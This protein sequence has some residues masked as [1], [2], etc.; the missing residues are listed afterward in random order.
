LV[1]KKKWCYSSYVA[2]TPA[3]GTVPVRICAVT[4]TTKSIL[5]FHLY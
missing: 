5:R 4:K 1:F 3:D 2:A